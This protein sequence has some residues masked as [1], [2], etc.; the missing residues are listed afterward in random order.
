[1]LLADIYVK[2]GD[3]FQ[4]KQYLLSLRKNYLNH[5]EIENLIEERL[6][7]IAKREKQKIIG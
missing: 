7:A 6:Q 1:V 3:D 5:D 4:A 2:K